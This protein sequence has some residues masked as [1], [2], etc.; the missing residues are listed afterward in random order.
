MTTTLPGL[1]QK[2]NGHFDRSGDLASTAAEFLRNPEG[3]A[4]RMAT[5]SAGSEDVIVPRKK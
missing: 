2:L 1:T 4:D 5:S 3:K